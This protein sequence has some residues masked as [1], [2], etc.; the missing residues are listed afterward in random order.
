MEESSKKDLKKRSTT[1]HKLKG[2]IGNNNK[3]KTEAKHKDATNAYL[4]EYS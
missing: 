4:R 2:F 3:E 1:I